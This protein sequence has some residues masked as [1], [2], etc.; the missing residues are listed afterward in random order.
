[1]LPDLPVQYPDY[2]GWEREQLQSRTYGA[3]ARVL[4][5]PVWPIEG[6]FQHTA[7]RQ[8]LFQYASRCAIR[9]D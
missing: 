4:E 7:Q 1:M 2:A 9:P 8:L 5:T 3:P 6:H